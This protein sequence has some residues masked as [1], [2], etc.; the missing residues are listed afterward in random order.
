MANLT[1]QQL[2]D[3]FVLAKDS[4]GGATDNNFLQWANFINQ[5]VYKTFSAINPNDY[6]KKYFILTDP[7]KYYYTLP[8]DFQ[9][10]S[11]GGVYLTGSTS[12]YEYAMIEFETQTGPFIVGETL[13][14]G[15]STA[16]A[17]ILQV[18]DNGTTGYLWVTYL[19]GEFVDGEIITSSG[20]G[21]ATI[22]DDPTFF[23]FSTPITETS[24]GSARS[25]YFI[26]LSYLNLYPTPT[27]YEV[28]AMKYLPTVSSLTAMSDTTLIPTRF[29]EFVR[30]AVAVYWQQWRD[31]PSGEMLDG[32]RYTYALT[33]LV[34][35]IAKTPRV[36]S[37]P[38]L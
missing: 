25:G 12:H 15:T 21:S 2:K 20:T 3:I 26:D 37:I 13:T 38:R 18:N 1:V 36:I 6:L 9:D 14:G 11:V 33:E 28:I 29:T 19:T 16:T 34:K 30:D 8:S 31:D 23:C 10:I 4:A 35:N 32:Q 17:K 5:F 7:E 24:E 27:E 22:A